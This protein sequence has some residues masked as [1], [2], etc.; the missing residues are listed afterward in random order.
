MERVEVVRGGGAVLYGS[1]AIG[2]VVNIITKKKLPNEVSAG[3]GNKGQQNYSVSAN[4]GKLSVAYNY[5]K[6]GDIGFISSTLT[7]ASSSADKEMKQHF[8]NSERM[9]FF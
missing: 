4:A 8:R 5:N 6:W 3:I 1:Q 2:G 7:P 9:I